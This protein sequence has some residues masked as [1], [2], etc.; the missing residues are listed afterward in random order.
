MNWQERFS[1]LKIG[2]RVRIIKKSTA[3]GC[4]V[5][6]V[7]QQFIGKIGT[8]CSI[9]KTSIGVDHFPDNTPWCSGFSKDCMQ[10]V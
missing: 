9:D 1:E 8:V 5:C 4:R 7:C 10:K 3:P 2:D 6:S